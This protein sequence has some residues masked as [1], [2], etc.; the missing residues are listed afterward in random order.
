MERLP[1]VGGGPTRTMELSRDAAA[2]GVKSHKQ[3]EKALI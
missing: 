1:L 3:E 2:G